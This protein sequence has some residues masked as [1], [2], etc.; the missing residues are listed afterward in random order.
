[1]VEHNTR[2][3]RTSGMNTWRAG[4][5]G[6]RTS[7]SEGGPE[8]PTRREP[9]RA[10]RP[11]PYTELKIQ[12]VNDVCKLVCGGLNGLPDAVGQVWW[13]CVVHTCIVHPLRNSFRYVGR[14]HW[15]AIGKARKP[16]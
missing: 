14:D 5:D 3:D 13:R 4:C 8:K 2:T 9:G 7:G 16:I 10:L 1:M 6:S 12:G 15:D 11:D